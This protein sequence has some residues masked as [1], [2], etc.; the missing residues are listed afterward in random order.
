MSTYVNYRPRPIR[1][2]NVASKL[3]EETIFVKMKDYSIGSVV[4]SSVGNYTGMVLIRDPIIVSLVLI[5][6]DLQK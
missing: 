1:I 2:L 5:G 4:I 6:L 3:I